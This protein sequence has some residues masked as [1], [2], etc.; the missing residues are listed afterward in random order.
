MLEGMN[1]NRFQDL[2][3]N[4][5]VPVKPTQT[6]LIHD[7][8]KTLSGLPP[9][10]SRMLVRFITCISPLKSFADISLETELS[11]EEIFRC[12]KHLIYWK[13]AKL[14]YPIKINVKNLEVENINLS[15]I[16][17]VSDTAVINKKVEKKFDEF[18][19]MNF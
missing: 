5:S 12:A 4:N 11:L 16:Y 1:E 13:Q 8:Q 14:I 10:A 2:D 6:L 3:F 15:N 17:R 7:T 9:D 19:K 18:M